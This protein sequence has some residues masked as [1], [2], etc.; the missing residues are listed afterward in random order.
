MSSRRDEAL[1]LLHRGHEAHR[2]G[3]IIRAS[4]DYR[5]ATALLPDLADGPYLLAIAELQIG[6]ARP[7][8]TRLKA[9]L[10]RFPPLAAI[11]VNLGLAHMS[12]GEASAAAIAF[13]SAAA[14]DPGE[15]TAWIELGNLRARAADY[16]GASL[17]FGRAVGLDPADAVAL[18]NL[19]GAMAAR[20][21]RSAD[22]WLRRSLASSP[23]SAR[24]WINAGH[25]LRESREWLA[26]ACA[27]DRAA[28]VEPANA[29]AQSE[30]LHAR[31]Q[32]ADW[33]DLPRRMTALRV[34]LE[35]GGAAPP[36]HLLALDLPP[37]LKRANAERWSAQYGA[38]RLPSRSSMPGKRLRLGYI[39]GDFR[40]HAVAYETIG[41]FE[42]H[43]RQRVDL[44]AYSWSADD[45]SDIRAR[46]DRVFGGIVD[47]GPMND[48]A[49]AA[50]IATDAVDVLIDLSGHT[51]GARPG[52]L[53]RR[54]APVQ[55]NYFG[56]PG[57]TGATYHDYVLADAIVAPTSSDEGYREAVV[58][59]PGCYWPHDERRKVGA[60]P[61]RAQQGLPPDAF[62]FVCFNQVYKIQP[63]SFAVWMKV[64]RSVPDSVLWLLDQGP[65]AR[66]NLKLQATR[67]GIE[68][69]RLIFAPPAAHDVHL[70][71]IAA[72]DLAVDT[73]PY[74]AHTT[75]SDALSVGCPMVAC[76]GADFAGRVCASMLTDLGF[77]QLIAPD[78]GAYADLVFGMARDRS[79][80]W[81]FRERLLARVKA[82]PLFDMQRLAR[83]V[84]DAATE[85]THRYRAGLAAV[86]FTVTPAG[87]TTSVRRDA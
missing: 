4:S 44:F 7:A 22:R 43:D 12:V 24:T 30:A 14:L 11:A 65:V 66:T 2:R 53:A 35:G 27:Y 60:A 38:D 39:G 36:F 42:A 34:A 54:P 16:A 28:M 47:I 57:V 70:A 6:E 48:E 15:A 19:G 61:D 86:G 85:M 23:A 1:A 26:A 69:T 31:L 71:R 46:L 25:G 17:L 52:I 50:R 10:H 72:A 80:L 45:G 56:F 18:G 13:R 41:L 40:R 81:A 79:R 74:N 83:S 78:A 55:V 5:R 75:A 32:I 49:A 3:D 87:I 29:T 63:S 21:S 20:G 8:A 76:L 62:V 73:Q 68:A 51:Y 37:S 77:D 9:L 64:M 84:E 67:Q 58:R 82:G 33:T 59:L